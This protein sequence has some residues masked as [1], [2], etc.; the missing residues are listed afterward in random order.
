MRR[1]LPYAVDAWP[2][3]Y[4]RNRQAKTK[5]SKNSKKALESS[6]KLESFEYQSS[7]SRA[8][9]WQRGTMRTANGEK[10]V[11]TGS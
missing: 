7:S 1:P 9:F 10:F 11:R 4:N 6:M 3:P 8:H 5:V 2:R